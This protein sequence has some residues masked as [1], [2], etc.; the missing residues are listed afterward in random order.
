MKKENFILLLFCTLLNLACS[1]GGNNHTVADTHLK[2]SVYSS[3]D[4]LNKAV[5]KMILKLYI[6][7]LLLTQQTVQ[8]SKIKKSF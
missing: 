8:I 1:K 4:E 2:K 6:L 5:Q 7:W 3:Q